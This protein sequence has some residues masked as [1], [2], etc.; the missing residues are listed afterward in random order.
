MC[1]KSLAF[2]TQKIPQ[3]STL[4]SFLFLFLIR[5]T[6]IRAVW[7]IY[8]ANGIIKCIKN[9]TWHIFYYFLLLDGATSAG[10]SGETVCLEPHLRE[11]ILIAIFEIKE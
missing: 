3:S 2:F 4:Y 1:G 5:L 10:F 9:L 11:P 6:T 7:L 8:L